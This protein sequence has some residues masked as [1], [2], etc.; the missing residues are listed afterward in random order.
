MSPQRDGL[1]RCA[2]HPG[3][4]KPRADSRLASQR[5]L[6]D[7]SVARRSTTPHPDRFVRSAPICDR[8]ASE[9]T[10]QGRRHEQGATHVARRRPGF[11]VQGHRPSPWSPP[12]SPPSASRSREA[13]T[14][15]SRTSAPSPPSTCAPARALHPALD[16][17]S[18]PSSRF[19]LVRDAE[20]RWRRGCRRHVL[21]PAFA[22]SSAGPGGMRIAPRPFRVSRLAPHTALHWSDSSMP[23]DA[24]ARR[25]LPLPRCAVLAET[26]P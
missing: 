9:R 11:P 13:T 6:P 23:S 3:S 22:R 10:P 8:T 18:R 1:R 21:A 24:G 25:G 15:R 26:P 12:C 7:L 5:C 2:R 19:C 4:L 14:S 16:R 17:R 20:G